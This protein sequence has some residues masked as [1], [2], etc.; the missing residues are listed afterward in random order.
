MNTLSKEVTKQFFGEE[1]DYARLKT[2]W[3][4]MINDKEARKSLQAEHHLL[5]LILMG[6]DWRKG[7]TACTNVKKLSNGQ[8]PLMGLRNA[9]YR[10]KSDWTIQLLFA[11]FEGYISESAIDKARSYINTDDLLMGDAYKDNITAAQRQKLLVERLNEDLARFESELAIH[12]SRADTTRYNMELTK[13]RI[14]EL[15]TEVTE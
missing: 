6:R 5:Y 1:N 12:E 10:F 2:H 15:D 13:K 11:P 7:F 9:L 3:S 4:K 14:V 8:N